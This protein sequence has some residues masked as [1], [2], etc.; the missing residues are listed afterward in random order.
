MKRPCRVLYRGNC[1]NGTGL[2]RTDRRIGGRRPFDDRDNRRQ[3][4]RA[5][6]GEGAV[7]GS[8]HERSGVVGTGRDADGEADG[9][10]VRSGHEARRT[11][12]HSAE[13]T[14]CRSA[15]NWRRRRRNRGAL[16]SCGDRSRRS[17]YA[18][19]CIAGGD[20]T[21]VGIDAGTGVINGGRERRKCSDGRR[22]HGG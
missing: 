12:T 13:D 21:G 16:M 9:L 3:C 18:S 14:A 19:T 20:G 5:D 4:R 6:G 17:G 2:E 10:R 8:K 22:R 7:D 1:R 15:G 11:G